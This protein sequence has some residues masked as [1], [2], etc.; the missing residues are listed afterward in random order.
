MRSEPARGQALLELA[1]FGSLTLIAV[2]F[3]IQIGLRV[4]YQQETDQQ[5]FR[6]AM[7]IA[8]SEGS[9]ESASIIHYQFRD[10]QVPDPSD[11]FSMMPRTLTQGMAN[12]VW[13]EHLAVGDRNDRR[14][15]ERFIFQVNSTQREFREEDFKVRQGRNIP[16]VTK[17]ERQ[18]TSSGGVQQSN[19]ASS[20]LST[21]TTQATTLTLKRGQTVPSAVTSG[22]D[23]NW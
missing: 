21:T 14:S 10:R 9:M 18:L 7:K 6:R 12:V 13:G 2:A 19:A 15:Q 16:I 3:L 23:W 5:T 22:V 11:G 20:Q 17:V 8:Q 4:N 1:I